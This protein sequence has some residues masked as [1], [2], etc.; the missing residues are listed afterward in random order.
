[1]EMTSILA[2][3]CRFP[4]LVGLSPW[5]GSRG[6]TRWAGCRRP[7]TTRPTRPDNMSM[8]GG[9][10]GYMVGC[11]METAIAPNNTHTPFCVWCGRALIS[12]LDQLHVQV[13]D[14]KMQ[15][16]DPYF[17]AFVLV[18][19]KLGLVAKLHKLSLRIFRILKRLQNRAILGLQIGY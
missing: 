14:P 11:Y 15:G 17:A 8:R 7:N 19:Q 9:G 12:I 1:M 16:R 10:Y 2:G 3:M 5:A 6:K 4:G 18:T 13:N